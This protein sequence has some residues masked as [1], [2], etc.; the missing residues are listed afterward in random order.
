MKGI[1]EIASKHKKPVVA[2]CGQVTLQEQQTKETG[3]ALAVSIS[4]PGLSITDAIERTGHYLR[5]AAEG[6]GD[7]RAYLA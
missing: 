5:S 3:L 4:P 7:L 1:V 6:L 2:L